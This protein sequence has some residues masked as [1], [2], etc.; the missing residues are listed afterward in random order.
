MVLIRESSEGERDREPYKLRG[1]SEDRAGVVEVGQLER[2]AIRCVLADRQP[3]V[4]IHPRILV[5]RGLITVFGGDRRRF[6]SANFAT[7]PSWSQ[8][9][10]ILRINFSRAVTRYGVTT[11][12][13]FM[14]ESKSVI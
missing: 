5:E 13:Y 14:D 4:Q 9:P 7:M 8:S 12:Q 3:L 11:P 2:V 6:S 10:S 1:T